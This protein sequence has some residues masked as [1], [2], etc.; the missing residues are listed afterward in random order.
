ML[1]KFRKTR[2]DSWSMSP[3]RTG[4]RIFLLCQSVVNGPVCNV[5]LSSG[6]SFLSVTRSNTPGAARS[7][8][9]YSRS[10]CT[11]SKHYLISLPICKSQLMTV[12]KPGRSTT[13]DKSKRYSWWVPTRLALQQSKSAR[14]IATTA[15]R[16][17]AKVSTMPEVNSLVFSINKG[18]C[19]SEQYIVQSSWKT[20]HPRTPTWGFQLICHLLFVRLAH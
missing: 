19:R 9:N 7:K 3:W 17:G 15:S 4:N 6:K 20:V 5:L 2:G 1:F 8:M 14:T 18:A 12:G 13:G 11:T 16:R 10:I